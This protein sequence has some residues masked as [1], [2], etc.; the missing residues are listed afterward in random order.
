IFLHA[1]RTE[2][3][4]NPVLNQALTCLRCGGCLYECPVYAVTA[5]H[6]GDKCFTSVGAVW[7][8]FIS[9]DREKAG[10]IAYTCLTCGRCKVRCPME[11]DGAEMTVALRQLI[12]ES[13]SL[14]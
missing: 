9:K 6:F 12:E 2:L 5:G 1:G 13:A 4:K 14:A 10:A 3:A 7:A 11:I 8:D